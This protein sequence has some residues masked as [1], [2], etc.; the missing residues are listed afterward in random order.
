[1]KKLS[2]YVIV[3]GAIAVIAA[4]AALSTLFF[5][6]SLSQNVNLSDL[7]DYGQAPNIQGISAWINS[8]PLNISQLRGKVVIVDFWTYSCINCIR[9]IP[10]LNALESTYGNDGLVIIGVH[11]PEF[12]FEHNLTNVE[13]AVKRFNITY[14]VALDNNY[15]TWDAYGNEY[16]PADYIIDK[17]GEIRYE[18]FGEGPTNF[19]DIQQV[20]RELLEN[21]GY[22]NLP[23]PVNVT[24]PLNF[25]QEISPEM[26]FG[27]AELEE[28]RTDYIGNL[29]G[30]RPN[31]VT[32][33]VITNFSQGYAI[34]L[35]GE[36]YSSPYNMTAESNDS[37]I[38]LLYRAKDVNFV[39]SG[40]IN[41]SRVTLLL[42]GTVPSAIY[43][44]SNSHL[45]GGKATVN[46]SAPKLYNIISAPSYG[47]HELE[48]NASPGFSIYTFTFG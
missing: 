33:Y 16:W 1:M 27:Y 46:V 6:K 11:T 10:F 35:S 21:A 4:I 23:A 20:V 38:I 18:S 29:N 7:Q 34:Y 37:R 2:I 9:T 31:N 17:N 32:D 45:L 3:F 40:N 8:P 36:W 42:N 43:L 5:N 41:G 28:G 13:N 19:N 44:G 48:I 15:A 47:Y 26:Y 39:A 12:Q 14:P 30:L 22:T 24:D 25:S